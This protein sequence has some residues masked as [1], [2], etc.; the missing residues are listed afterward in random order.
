L[1]QNYLHRDLVLG[2]I[3]AFVFDA[4]SDRQKP[5]F[6]DRVQS[7]RPYLLEFCFDLSKKSFWGIEFKSLHFPF[8][9]CEKEN[10]RGCEIGRIRRMWGEMYGHL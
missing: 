10:I 4:F 7:I 3:G 9:I 5:A 8:Q 1:S 2:E 6:K